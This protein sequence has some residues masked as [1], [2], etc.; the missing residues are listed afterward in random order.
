MPL[1]ENANSAHL[2]SVIGV[3][4]KLKPRNSFAIAISHSARNI[5]LER[6]KRKECLIIA[7]KKSH[8]LALPRAQVIELR[9]SGEI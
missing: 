7:S 9:Q 4:R 1:V 2:E 5:R 3:A 8:F 6:E